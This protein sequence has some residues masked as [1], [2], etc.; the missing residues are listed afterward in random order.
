MKKSL[1]ALFVF[2][3]LM[4]VPA[5][6]SAT[7]CSKNDYYGCGTPLGDFLHKLFGNTSASVLSTTSG[8]YEVQSQTTFP[9]GFSLRAGLGGYEVECGIGGCS[10]NHDETDEHFHVD[11]G[12]EF[13]A[14]PLT[15]TT[16]ARVHHIEGRHFGYGAGVDAGLS[17]HL[18]LRLLYLHDEDSPFSDNT[19]RELAHFGEVHL[20]GGFRF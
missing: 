1:T 15:F 2:A 16:F 19:P 4:L 14:G 3:A 9:S 10:E 13:D 5:S 8:G 7:D 12:Y 18:Y 17:K 6:A 20:Y 11:A